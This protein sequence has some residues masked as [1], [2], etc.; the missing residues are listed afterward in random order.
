MDSASTRHARL[1][2]GHPGLDELAALKTWMAATRPAMT[3]GGV[4][5]R[6][7]SGRSDARSPPHDQIAVSSVV[8]PGP[9][10]YD[11]API[12]S[13]FSGQMAR[14]DGKNDRGRTTQGRSA[15]RRHRPDSGQQSP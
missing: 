13:T 1:Y 3:L 2:A 12:K 10:G 11:F 4:S 15:W 7:S 14:T 9:V 5:S 6:H 8:T